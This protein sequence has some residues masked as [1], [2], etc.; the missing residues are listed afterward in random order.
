MRTV[1]RGGRRRRTAGRGRSETSGFTRE[2]GR[3]R[4]GN[5]VGVLAWGGGADGVGGGDGGE[6]GWRRNYF[7]NEEGRAEFSTGALQEFLQARREG[8]TRREI[9]GSESGEM[10]GGNRRRKHGRNGVDCGHGESGWRFV[11]D[12]MGEKLGKSWSFCRGG[13]AG[14]AR[15]VGWRGWRRRWRWR[16]WCGDLAAAAAAA[17]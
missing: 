7:G 6:E 5:P 1:V 4:N 14:A 10:T 15:T 8:E 12:L 3:E 17:A 2:G 11:E 13:A 16:W 9:V